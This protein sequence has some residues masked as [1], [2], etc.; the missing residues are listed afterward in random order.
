MTKT[1][2]LTLAM[3]ANYGAAFGTPIFVAS[4]PLRAA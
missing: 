3:V 1:V 2:Q 4:A